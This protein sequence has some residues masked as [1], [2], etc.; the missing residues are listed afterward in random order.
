[1][2]QR[3]RN[4]QIQIPRLIP[5]VRIRPRVQ[6]RRQQSQVRRRLRQLPR[7]R[8]ARIPA[9]LLPIQRLILR[10]NLARTRRHARQPIP[11]AQRIAR[12]F[13]ACMHSLVPKRRT[14]WNYP[15][16]ADN[17]VVRG[18]TIFRTTFRRTLQAQIRR[19]RQHNLS[20]L[21]IDAPTILRRQMLQR[22]SRVIIVLN[23]LPLR[24]VKVNSRGKR[25][26]IP[27]RNQHPLRLRPRKYRIRRV[28]I[29]HIRRIPLVVR[30]VMRDVA[31]ESATHLKAS[32]RH[33]RPRRYQHAHRLQMS[34]LHRQLQYRIAVKVNSVRV[35]PRVQQ[36]HH[37]RRLRRRTIQ[38][39]QQ[40]LIRLI[41]ANPVL[42]KIIPAA[43]IA[44]TNPVAIHKLPRRA[45]PAFAGPPNPLP[46]R[47]NPAGVAGKKSPVIAHANAILRKRTRR[48]QSAS[49]VR[50]KMLTGGTRTS[51]IRLLRRCRTFP[52]NSIRQNKLPRRTSATSIAL[53]R[54][55]G[56]AFAGAFRIIRQR[57]LQPRNPARCNA[58]I[59][60][61][62]AILPA[63]TKSA[64]RRLDAPNR[65]R[66][67]LIRAQIRIIGE[68]Q[69]P[70]PIP[71][72]AQIRRHRIDRLLL[73][74]REIR[75]ARFCCQIFQWNL[76]VVPN[77]RRRVI[78]RP[79]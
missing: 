75:R 7:Q 37:R 79:I 43:N 4:F 50:T 57:R 35:R 19:H 42:Q 1:M 41:H 3:H 21:P 56:N 72:T 63:R 5:P 45:Q 60:V 61:R 65:A 28:P 17:R 40:Q 15:V 16:L 11:P 53:N 59:P 77:R 58:R 23:S 6:Q 47:T 74:R 62:R 55:P 26:G 64:M 70:T 32:Q 54:R 51:P 48:T 38:L 24:P 69:I 52:A 39:V 49:P 36:R 30:Q 22:Q 34:A 13:A 27:K 31:V 25:Q 76:R 29:K 46:V 10:N 67:S 78:R 66:Q 71:L 33:I 14:S 20:F 73:P 44:K 2:T 18:K 8:L 68:E 12:T 9:L